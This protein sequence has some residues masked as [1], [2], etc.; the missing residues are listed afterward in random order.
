MYKHICIIISYHIILHMT[1][2][3]CPLKNVFWTSLLLLLSLS[4]G[5]MLHKL[6]QINLERFVEV[7]G[8]ALGFLIQ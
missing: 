1:Y 4:E 3:L 5:K 7:I 6:Y 2:T 8:S